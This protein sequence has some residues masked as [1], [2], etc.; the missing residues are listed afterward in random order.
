MEAG[1]LQKKGQC[2]NDRP[3]IGKKSAKIVELT[4]F[5]NRTQFLGIQATYL[6]GDVEK[7]GGQNVLRREKERFLKDKTIKLDPGD[8]FKTFECSINKED[9]IVG[10]LAVSAQGKLHKAGLLEGFKKE[11]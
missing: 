8:Y 6:I 9:I 5:E 2:F 1:K 4:L 7:K 10:L 11:L 3:I